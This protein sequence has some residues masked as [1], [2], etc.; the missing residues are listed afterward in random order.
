MPSSSFQFREHF[1]SLTNPI[2]HDHIYLDGPGGTQVP[3]QVIDEIGHYYKNFNAN[4]HGFFRS[5]IE[6]DAVMNEARSKVAAFLN[7]EGNHCVSFGQNMTSLMFSLSRGIARTLEPGDEILITQLDHESNR[8]P[9]LKL[10][11]WGIEVRE[12]KLTENGTLDYK[13]F[14]EKIN[15]RT[16]VVAMGCASNA[17]GTVNDI[18]FARKITYQYG[19][20]LVLDAVHYAPHFSIDVQA[21][22]CDFLFCSAY[23]FYGPHVGIMYAKPDLLNRI[24]VDNLRTQDQIAPYKIETG[25]LNHAAIAGTSAA[26]DFI[27]SYGNG[28]NLREQLVDSMVKIGK[29]ERIL[30]E[31]LYNGLQSIKQVNIVGPA[32]GK[33]LRA[34]TI[35]LTFEG[36][37]PEQLCKKLADRNIYVWDGHFYAIRAI[38]CMGLFEKGGVSRFGISA[39]TTEKE[40]ERVIETMNLIKA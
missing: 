40:I 10:R 19:S 27:A 18:A 32:F 12:I 21:M 16:R 22:G 38:E 28:K 15:E 5:S 6:T 17:F 11:E 39:Y 26:I 33:G 29:R 8:G 34:P 24:P 35:S 37:R 30:G 2:Y 3:N 1:P 13:D 14:E 4:T 23:K 9:W 25:T 31:K 7:A 20:L 36:L